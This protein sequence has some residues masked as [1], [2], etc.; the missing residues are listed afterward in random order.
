[1][2]VIAWD[3]KTIA[4]DR[5]ATCSDMRRKTV[6]LD[7]KAVRGKILIFGW[8]GIDSNGRELM[9]WYVKG[10]D[11]AK[12]PASQAT[13]DW[14]RLLVA[15]AKRVLEFEQ[16]PYPIIHTRAP[17]A[18]GSGRDFAV[19]AMAMGANADQAVQIACRYNV[20]CGMGV[21]VFTLTELAKNLDDGQF[22]PI[23]KTK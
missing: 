7:C 19:G 3:G 23:R 14:T 22:V 9:D 15:S 16:R 1:M 11:V 12:W 17:L 21:T 4:A 10:A 8:T 2:S 20:S 6:K 5:Q 13:S 18:W